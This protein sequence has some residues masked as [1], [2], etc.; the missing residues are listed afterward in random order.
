MLR[1]SASLWGLAQ[2]AG[3]ALASSS[4]AA[5]GG[6]TSLQARRGFNFVPYVIES[7]S[8]GE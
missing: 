4:T 8:R 3:A 2:Q 1:A 6:A 7:T 5:I